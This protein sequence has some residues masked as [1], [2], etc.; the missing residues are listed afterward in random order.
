MVF[1]ASST[2]IMTT[3][4]INKFTK[5]IHYN[6]QGTDWSMLNAY[7]PTNVD[8]VLLSWLTSSPL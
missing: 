8:T 4:I 3:I 1:H 5:C 2:I 6:V 7:I